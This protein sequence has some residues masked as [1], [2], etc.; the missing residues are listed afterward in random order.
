MT[1]VFSLKLDKLFFFLNWSM[2]L[3]ICFCLRGC[4][5][6]SS[7]LKLDIQSFLFSTSF[8]H[9]S[10]HASWQNCWETLC[11]LLKSGT[12]LVSFCKVQ[13]VKHCSF[14]LNH[15]QMFLI[16]IVSSLQIWPSHIVRCVS[17]IQWN[18]SLFSFTTKI[19]VLWR[20]RSH[21]WVCTVVLN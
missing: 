3:F 2:C 20:A 8:C 15:V 9:F 6:S 18:R 16:V 14:V 17:A 11:K 5:M 21:C 10:S 1:K 12:S 19:W 13:L 7:H 4:S